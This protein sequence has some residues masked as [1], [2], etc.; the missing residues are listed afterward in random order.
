MI[1][2]YLYNDLGNFSPLTSTSALSMDFP[3][4]EP[5]SFVLNRLATL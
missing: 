2:I 3:H 4:L 5:V 1:S